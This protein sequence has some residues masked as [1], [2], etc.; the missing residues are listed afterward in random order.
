VTDLATRSGADSATPDDGASAA[1]DA[2]APVAATTATEVLDAPAT[3]VP[4]SP[5]TADAAVL[6]GSAAIADAAIA[7]SAAHPGATS[8]PS[9][10][11]APAEPKPKKRRLGLWIGIPAG[12]A[13]AA[14]V[15]ASLTLIAPGTSIA[16]VA[17]GGMTAGGAADALQN[18]L[19]ET[20]VVLTGPGVDAEITG[21]QLG[22]SVVPAAA[23]TEVSVTGADLGATVDAKGLA[24][25]AFAQ[26]PMWN[27]TTWFS[28]PAPA[29]VSLDADAATTAL[30]AAAPSLYKDPVDAIVAFDAAS[31]SYVLT[32]SVEGVG[33]D[34]DAVRAALQSAF[35]A[36]QTRVELAATAAPIEARIPTAAAQ[37]S[38]DQLN[39]I[40]A[41]AGF[42]VGA[43]RT[44]PL[45]RATVASW[46]TLST[47]ADGAIT[48]DV[49]QAAIQA[50]VDTLPAAIDRPSVNA[51]VITDSSGGTLEE[52]TVGATGRTIGSTDGVA[53][54]FAEQLK[55]GDGVYEL[56]VAETPFT[57]T[58][59]ARRIEVN[60]SEQRAY[61]FENEQV[62]QSWYISS[63]KEGYSSSTG[64]F[65]IRAKLTSQD[66]G[67]PD[68][69]KAPN[70][71]TPDVPDVM[72]Y[73]GDEALH[74]AYWHNNFGNVMSH[75]CINMPLSAAEFTFG[76]APMGTEV[77]VHY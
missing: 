37:A 46:L 66:M 70:Y 3:E 58:T 43:E 2:P 5:G 45:D 29:S 20:T 12:I 55:T 60:L 67:N 1:L 39:D 27:P 57:T 63:G 22:A 28:S 49:D 50:V 42:Y 26:H 25:A 61:L 36:G 33:I 23:E 41:T 18:R 52:E 75:G 15:A 69:T 47:D 30:R 54:G 24:D 51:T 53:A 9:Y 10:V 73:N 14:L 77:W 62:V 74:G 8:T 44:V 38:V 7:D 34:L 32:P 59:L 11:W 48:Y 76:W 4:D 72:Y 17:V 19:D 35:E 56:T 6:A 65:R 13:I 71:F 31:A 40:L 16:G 21:G 64:H 68:L